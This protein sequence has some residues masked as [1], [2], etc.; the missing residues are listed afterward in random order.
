MPDASHPLVARFDAAVAAVEAR[1]EELGLQPRKLDR[2][3][4]AAYTGRAAERGWRFSANFPDQLR[5]LDVI[6]TKGFPSIP[7]RVALVDRPPFLTWPH[8][9]KDG[10]LCLFPDTTT[11]SVDDP[12]DGVASLLAE[13]FR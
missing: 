10:V 7:A 9:E 3:E 11:M 5:R 8:V 6:V 4:L 2:R 12:Y 13:A 1:W